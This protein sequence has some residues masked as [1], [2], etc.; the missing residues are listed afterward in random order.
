MKKII[1][2]I[3]YSLIIL[4]VLNC[5]SVY[6]HTIKDYRIKEILFVI[7]G[8]LVAIKASTKNSEIKGKLSKGIV[9]MI[10]YEIYAILF[11]LIN[12]VKK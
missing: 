3:E 6:Q 9:Y 10:I 5:R 7:L 11:Y 4:I 2:V 1:N 12:K 8:L